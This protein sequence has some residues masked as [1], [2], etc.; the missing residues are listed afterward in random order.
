MPLREAMLYKRENENINAK[1]RCNVCAHQCLI[2]EDGFGICR[3]RQNR[4]GKLYT[5][6]YAEASSFN[7]DPVE[8][9]P[10]LLYTSPSPRD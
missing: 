8:K 5:L 4:T 7:A 3:T 10:C 1:V 9:K 6:I 2:P